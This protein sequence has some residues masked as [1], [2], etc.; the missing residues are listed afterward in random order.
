MEQTST[1]FADAVLTVNKA[2]K[3]IYS[4]RSCPPEKITIVIN[5]PDEGVFKSSSPLPRKRDVEREFVIMYHGSLVHRNGFDLAIEAMEMVQR[6]IPRAVLVV[7]G[8]RTPFFDTVM[9]SVQDRRLK[10]KVRYLG[11]QDLFQIV[12]TINQCDLGIVPNHRNLFTEINTPTRIFEYL[13]LGKPVIAP[14]AGG[15]L[16]YFGEQDLIYFNLGDSSDLARQVEYVYN[17]PELVDEIVKRGQQIYRS[18][19]WTLERGE[20]V[21]AVTRL[22]ANHSS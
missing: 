12:A 14:R 16:D 4:S 1:R 2:C 8:A 6:T 10:E 5:S 3:R 17:N 15:I 22:F 18:H 21:N 13:A 19:T 7:C 9:E 11:P 20:L